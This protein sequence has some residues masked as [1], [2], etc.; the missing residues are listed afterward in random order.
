MTINPDGQIVIWE[1]KTKGPSGGNFVPS[2]FTDNQL[3]V[4]EAIKDGTV[5]GVR[6]SDDIVTDALVR[7]ADETLDPFGP[8]EVNTF[9]VS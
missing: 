2:D 6:S 3:I 7:V 8:T 4:F 5:N 9:R 1:A